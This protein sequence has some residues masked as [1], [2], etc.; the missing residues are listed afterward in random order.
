MQTRAAAIS[1]ALTLSACAVAAPRIITKTFPIADFNDPYI[2][3]IP[4]GDPI[5]GREVVAASVFLNVAAHPGSDARYFQTEVYFPIEAA[6]GMS[7]VLRLSGEDMGWHG[8]G[9]FTYTATFPSVRGIATSGLFGGSSYA[10]D[11]FVIA[12]V[13][14][15]SRVE[16]DFAVVP[17]PGAVGVLALG[18]LIATRRRRVG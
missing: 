5:I 8:A 9:N 17:A 4:V 3:F 7:N 12:S 18:T 13:L 10:I 6:S 2:G 14:P 1:I 15:S 11:G 16:L